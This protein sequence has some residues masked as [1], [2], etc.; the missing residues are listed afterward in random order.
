[1]ASKLDIARQYVLENYNNGA[2]FRWD[3]L[4]RKLQVK[5]P[6]PLPLSSST[7]TPL[8]SREGTGVG[9]WQD[10]DT[11]MINSIACACA[12]ERQVN[13]TD[14]EVRIV[15]N[16]E[17]IPAVNPLRDYVY[18]LEEYNPNDHNGYSFI[19][20]LS[21]QVTIAIGE[22][23]GDKTQADAQQW[24]RYC[25]KKWFVAMVA[26]WLFDDVV[27]QEV[28]ILIGRQGI[29]KTTWLERLMPPCLS[30]YCTKMG[31]PND[32]NKD[33]KLRTTEF[34]LVCMDEVD[35]YQKRELNAAKSMITT[36]TVTE[37]AAYAYTKECRVRVASFCGSGNDPKI[38]T[39]DTGNRR[40]L[41]FNVEMIENPYNWNRDIFP[42]AQI[43]GEALYL[44][45]HG[46]CYWFDMDDIAKIEEHNQGHMK[47]PNEKDL[48]PV[49]FSP[50]KPGDA[51]AVFMTTAE[52][53]A[54]LCDWGSIKHPMDV[55]SLGKLIQSMGFPQYR[56]GHKCVRGYVVYV[57]QDLDN[58]R[59]MQAREAVE[60]NNSI[61]NAGNAD[62]ADNIF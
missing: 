52:I 20:W 25:F 23:S 26:C 44:V 45:R 15:L 18:N 31:S 17:D 40:W 53:S 32:L 41:M 12:T 61:C 39:D 33:E 5:V 16:S 8:P 38:L 55:R 11:R 36:A 7:P 34:G 58:Q 37:R 35:A 9:L 14:R 21:N 60:I 42:Y 1:M 13:V 46:F 2:D 24:W 59:K 54:K 51:G 48:L 10:V 57:N 19:D 30:A 56:V 43:Y 6:T 29:Y 3:L 27:N 49:Y 50:A 47:E 22:D 28:L 62:M 4:S